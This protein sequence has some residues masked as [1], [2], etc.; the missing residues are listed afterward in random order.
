MVDIVESQLERVKVRRLNSFLLFSVVTASSGWGQ[1]NAPMTLAQALERART[2]AP[3]ILVAH[4]RIEEA[5]GRLTGA[6]VLQQE[7]P[8]VASSVGPSFFA[9][10]RHNRL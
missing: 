10:R 6:S 7:N 5:R 1:H 9:Q 4:E 2:R 3:R 8:V